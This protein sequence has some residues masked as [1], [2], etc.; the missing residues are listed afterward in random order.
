MNQPEFDFTA[1]ARPQFGTDAHKLARTE[2]PDTSHAAAK[3]VDTTKLEEMVYIA[4]SS[5]GAA[6]CIQDDVLARFPG[7][8]YSS[9]TARFKALLDKKLIVDT[10]E[11]RAGR[12]GRGQ[13]ILRVA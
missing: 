11:R 5:F 13:R 3:S 8:P 9:V 1:P 7:Y 12:S 4:I 6:G 2:D 10:G